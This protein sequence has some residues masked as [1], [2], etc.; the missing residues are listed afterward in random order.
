[1]AKIYKE[2]TI[3]NY[4]NSF[5]DSSSEP[6]SANIKQQAKTMQGVGDSLVNQAKEDYGTLVNNQSQQ[7]MNDLLSNPSL[8]SNPK[9][10]A[11]EMDKMR[12]KISSEIVDDDVKKNFLIN[13][14]LN[15]SSYVNKAQANFDNIQRQKQK[16]AAFDSV[17]NSIDSIGL[18]FGNGI[19]GTGNADDLINATRANASILQKINST[20]PDGTYVFTDEQRRR[21]AKDLENGIFNSFKSSFYDI[22]EEKRQA[23]IDNFKNSGGVV[24]LPTKD[25]EA[26]IKYS[27]LLEPQTYNKVKEFVDQQEYRAYLAQ[28]RKNAIKEYQEKQEIYNTE[29]D[30]SDRLDDMDVDLAIRE[31]DNNQNQV[32]EKFYKSK[33]KALLSEKGITAETQASTFTDFVLRVNSI[34]TDDEKEFFKLSNEVLSELE[35][36]YASGELKLSDKRNLARNLMQRQ[37]K[38]L[39]KLIEKESSWFS[40]YDYTDAYE[41]LKNSLTAGEANKAML[42]YHRTLSEKDYNTKQKKELIKT[43]INGGKKNIIK[44]M[45]KPRLTVGMVDEGMRYKGGN[46]KSPESWEEE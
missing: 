5:Y 8:S 29:M 24:S 34:S 39:P 11:G 15:K 25:G 43:L 12:D 7:A 38:A 30:L 3:S 23:F 17:Y 41:D 1:M 10:L 40:S 37:G 45:E 9:A 20:Y 19:M 26:Q 33:M 22:P 36:A 21:F 27:D 42:E 35:D 46:P 4:A 44:E 14:E 16:S 31:L 32:S 28:K 6:Y 13:Y 2:K 18:A